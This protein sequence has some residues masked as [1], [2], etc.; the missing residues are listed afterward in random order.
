MADI[1]SATTGRIVY[2]EPNET[3]GGDNQPV[4]QEDLTKYVNLS[5]RIPSRIYNGGGNRI[6]DSILK[7]TPFEKTNDGYTKFYLTD[8]Y[9]NM[10]YTEFGSDGEISTGEL[11]GI[12]SINIS[13]DVQ[14]FPQVVINFIDIKGLGLM[15]TMEYNYEHGKVNNLTAKSFFTSLFNFPYPIFTLEVKGYYGKSMSFDLTL[16]DFHTAF[17]STTG[18]FRTTVSF[19]GHL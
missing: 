7:G 12:E 6:Y 4:N 17:D 13:F 18:N 10:T 19:I 5:V 8:N 16:K 11:F 9:V 14:F 2:F 3:F 15:S 1:V